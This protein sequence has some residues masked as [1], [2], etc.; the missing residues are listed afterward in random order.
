MALS[1][2]T[3]FTLYSHVI[4]NKST[5]LH[6]A[7]LSTDC[8]YWRNDFEQGRQIAEHGQ[9]ERKRAVPHE[10]TQP[11]PEKHASGRPGPAHHGATD[12]AN[13][14]AVQP[15]PLHVLL[16]EGAAPRQ[17][18]L[19]LL[20]LCDLHEQRGRVPGVQSGSSRGA[21]CRQV[22]PGARIWRS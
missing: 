4:Q 17:L 18:R 3:T 14:R 20:R 12:R 5:D 6:T 1:S 15:A 22:Q 8:R 19:G 7:H 16:S 10:S 2:H 11:A 21:R 9:E 13:R